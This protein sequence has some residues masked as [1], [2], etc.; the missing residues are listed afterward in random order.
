M[1]YRNPDPSKRPPAELWKLCFVVQC[2]ASEADAKRAEIEALT[3][4]RMSW[5][6]R[7]DAVGGA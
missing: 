3:G 5:W 6:S 7:A 2:T 1:T 4:A